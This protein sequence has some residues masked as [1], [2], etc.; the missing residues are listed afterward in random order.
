[1]IK[2]IYF[3]IGGF[4][5]EG[6]GLQIGW[7]FGKKPKVGGSFSIQK[8]ILHILGAFNSAFWAWN[9]FK[10]V[11]SGFRV[12]FFNNCIEKNQNQTHFGEGTS[13]SLYYLAL[14]PIGIYATISIQKICNIIF[15]K[16]GGGS[17]AVWNFSQNSSDLLAWP[18][19]YLHEPTYSP[20]SAWKSMKISLSQTFSTVSVHDCV[21]FLRLFTFDFSPPLSN[22]H[23]R[24]LFWTLFFICFFTLPKWANN[25]KVGSQMRLSYLNHFY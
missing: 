9:W 22:V 21:F 18:V 24:A 6:S 4:L 3:L 12:S 23:C 20:T 25:S 7:I 5:R 11:I 8:F 15:R 16:W 13:E 2:I 19:A 17:K 10:R 1:M 14:I